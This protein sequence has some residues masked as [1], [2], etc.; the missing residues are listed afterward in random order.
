MEYRQ[1]GPVHCTN[2]IP[3]KNWSLA[4]IFRKLRY[5]SFSKVP[6]IFFI[7]IS[8]LRHGWDR[9]LRSKV[10]RRVSSSHCTTLVSLYGDEQQ[11]VC[12][13]KATALLSLVYL[14]Y[15]ERDMR[16][17]CSNASVCRVP[18]ILTGRPPLPH[19]GQ[20]VFKSAPTSSF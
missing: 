12:R 20:R 15:V 7:Y 14:Y 2:T 13:R 10:F 9:P 17:A 3:V 18:C 4:L 16:G 6:N 11:P 5:Q 19:L 1:G 8:S